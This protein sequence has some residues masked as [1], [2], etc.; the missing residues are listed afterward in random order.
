LMASK[1]EEEASKPPI[2]IGISGATRSGKTSLTEALTKHF[3][4]T[5]PPVHMDQY[6]KDP[7]PTHTQ[8]GFINWE[9][10]LAVDFQSSLL[11]L[12]RT[13]EKAKK[14]N[15]KFVIIEGFLL[16]SHDEIVKLLD[17]KIFL[18]IGK[19]ECFQRRMN[20]FAV[21][22]IYFDQILWEEYVNNN[23][24]VLEIDDVCILDAEAAE[25]VVLKEAI[26]FINGSIREANLKE[27]LHSHLNLRGPISRE[28]IEQLTDKD[29]KEYLL[30]EYVSQ[31]NWNLMHD[32]TDK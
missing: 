16:F 25:T 22:L 11:H 21:S 5:I 3:R 32:N 15:L 8:T 14:D 4:I 18:C 9:T 7:A 10:P 24:R 29:A 20:T 31:M 27:L 17:K 19:K 23:K 1:S 13:I 30:F 28:W 6:W 2:V 26:N 12:K